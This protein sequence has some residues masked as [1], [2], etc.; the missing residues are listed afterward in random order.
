MWY[1]MNAFFPP[2]GCCD[3]TCISLHCRKG[4]DEFMAPEL[5]FG[6]PYDEKADVFS[7]GMVLAEMLTR[8]KPDDH[9]LAR[10][11]MRGFAVDFDELR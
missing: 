10:T 7:F 4:T 2:D 9:F 1:A 8:R 5:I 11:P 6:M 3:L